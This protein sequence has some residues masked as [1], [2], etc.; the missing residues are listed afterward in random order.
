LPRKFIGQFADQS[1]LSYLN[2]RY[3]SSERGQF[4]SQDPVF[5]GNPKDQTLENPQSLNSYSYAN[6]NPITGKD[7][8]GRQVPPQLITLLIQLVTALTNYANF[9]SSS[10]G[11]VAV[12]N[13][14]QQAPTMKSPTATFGQKFGAGVSIGLSLMPEFSAGKGASAG[15]NALAKDVSAGDQVVGAAGTAGKVAWPSGANGAQVIDGIKYSDHAL[16]SMA[17]VGTVN[18]GGTVGRGI[19]PSVVK[20]AIEHGTQTPS[21]GNRTVYTYENVKAVTE[22]DGTVVTVIKTG[23]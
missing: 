21:Y 6:D 23:N 9:L 7:P 17:P 19:P 11:Q 14:V 4:I 12:S 5:W 2:A 15:A 10:A 13:A 3:Y 8:D 22:S 16:D 18:S 20:N 1:G